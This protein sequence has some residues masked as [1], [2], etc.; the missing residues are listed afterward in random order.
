MLLVPATM[1]KG[2]SGPHAQEGRSFSNTFPMDLFGEA[3]K[4]VSSR[5]LDCGT[6]EQDARDSPS[7]DC[8]SLGICCPQAEGR[9]QKTM[10]TPDCVQ[11]S[12]PGP[13]PH[14]LTCHLAEVSDSSLEVYIFS[15]ESGGSTVPIS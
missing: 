15:C 8:I 6:D 4:L 3:F 11:S 5:Y 14:H 7:C 9:L 12:S 13:R 2:A 1:V 10:G